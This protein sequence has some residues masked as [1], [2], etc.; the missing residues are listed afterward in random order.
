LHADET[1]QAEAA[2]PLEV[3]D[4]LLRLD[5]RIGLIERRHVDGHV[6]PQHLALGGVDREPIERSQRVRRHDRTEPLNHVAV[7]VV[8]RWL[9]QDQLKAALRSNAVRHT[10]PLERQWRHSARGILEASA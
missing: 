5:P 3:G 2:E 7:V 8:M 6:G 1:D 4:D 9:D 10:R